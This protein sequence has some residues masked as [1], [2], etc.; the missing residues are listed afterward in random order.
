MTMTMRTET[1]AAAS[2][3]AAREN[4]G[5]MIDRVLVG[6]GVGVGEQQARGADGSDGPDRSGLGWT[7]SFSTKPQKWLL[8]GLQATGPS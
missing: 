3:V 8:N 5:S 4:H 6:V 7:A 2:L 1:D